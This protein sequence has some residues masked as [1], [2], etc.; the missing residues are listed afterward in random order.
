[1]IRF[2]FLTL[3]VCLFISGAPLFAGGH[4]WDI[5]ELYSN[6]DG[7]IQF[8]ELH[9]PMSAA[10]ELFMANKWIRSDATN[11]EFVF[12]ENLT[13]S[14]AFAHLLIATQGFAN[15]TDG[16]IAILTLGFITPTFGTRCALGNLKW[17]L[18]KLET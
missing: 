2:S 12:P 9:V 6:S 4:L 13:G 14:T 7:T 15:L 5:N 16:I 1:M 17:G 10:S 8:V 18:N 11:S 3:F